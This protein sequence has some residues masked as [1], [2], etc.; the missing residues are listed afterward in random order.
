M[1][2]SVFQVGVYTEA[3][4]SPEAR[5]VENPVVP[6]DRQDEARWVLRLN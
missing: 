6:F 3:T 5:Q 4:D 2:L 1:E